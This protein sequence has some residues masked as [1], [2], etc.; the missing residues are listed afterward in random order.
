MDITPVIPKGHNIIKG[1]GDMTFKIN[2]DEYQ[3][4]LIVSPEEVIKWQAESHTD[5]S[6]PILEESVKFEDTE[7]LLIGCGSTHKPIED[8]VIIGL[9][10]SGVGVEVMTTGAACRTYNVLLAEGRKVVAALILV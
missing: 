1:Y 9:Q 6:V 2:D 3:S 5:I 4:S 7:I 10:K 8:K